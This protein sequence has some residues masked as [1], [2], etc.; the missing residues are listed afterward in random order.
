MNKLIIT[1]SLLF[2]FAYAQ[3]IHFNVIPGTIKYADEKRFAGDTIFL[4]IE[5]QPNTIRYIAFQNKNTD[6]GIQGYLY[7]A[8]RKV[9]TMI[10]P[11]DDYYEFTTN[12]EPLSYSLNRFYLRL[13]KCF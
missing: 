4:K 6:L 2:S 8:Y 11:R 12:E 13:V 3:Q 7:D 10:N 1:I 5:L 9:T